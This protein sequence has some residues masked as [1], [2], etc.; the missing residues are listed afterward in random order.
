MKRIRFNIASLLGVI[1]ILG[2]AFA[3][4]RESNDLWDSA[5]FTL[6]LVVLAISI[7]LAIHRAEKKRAFWLGFALFGSAYLGLSSVASIEPRLITTKALAYLDS[8]M[9][10][11]ISGGLGYFEYS[12]N[13][14]QD[15]R[16]TAQSNTAWFSNIFLGPAL[17]GSSGP[18]ENFIRIGHSLL[19]LTAA[20]L[21][22]LLSRNFFAKNREPDS[23]PV[24]QQA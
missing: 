11:S 24:N 21:G 7:L 19:A 22:G 13:T 6:T 16:S 5:F 1:L 10:R 4:L 8:K 23:G 20:F 18:T 2:V 15:L 3:A 12:D 9:P 14:F 17:A